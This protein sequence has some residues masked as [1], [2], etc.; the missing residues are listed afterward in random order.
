MNDAVT[1]VI[2]PAAAAFAASFV[3]VRLL[4]RH[5]HRVG[6]VDLPNARSSHVRACPRGG[7][8]G[9]VAGVWLAVLVT[10][11]MMPVPQS[12]WTVL[13][14]ASLV[15]CVGLW[16]DLRGLGV[17]PRLT[18]HTAAAVWLVGSL[19]GI[20]RLPLPSP[21]D[22]P[23]G[24]LGPAF[25][26]AWLVGVTN[27]FNF[28][29]GVDGLAAGQAIITL[30]TVAFATW[31]NTPAGLAVA[32]AAATGAFLTRNWSPARIFLGD[33][34]SAFL[35]LLLA[36]LPFAA[37]PPARPPLVLLVATS[38]ALFLLDPAATLIAR[39]RRGA[40]IGA[41]HREHA[42]QQFVKPGAPHG[43]AVSVLLAAGAGL[44]VFAAAAFARPALGWPILAI[45]VTAFVVEWRAAATLRSR[46][47]RG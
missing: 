6:L 21:M 22:L 29:D 33:V 17:G 5:A 26:V 38:L 36:G 16:D 20:D 4:E 42:Y 15:A 43:I 7:G 25:A 31:P 8:L 28:M 37:S 32:A 47:G 23:L 27:F 24:H 12:V 11:A 41:A 45:V 9:I 30:A 14:A 35:G 1:G 44:S 40:K 2:A 39:I 10:A 3:V 19:G 18:V 13:A 46:R 34:G